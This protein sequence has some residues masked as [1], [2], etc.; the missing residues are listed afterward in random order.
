MNELIKSLHKGLIVSYQ[1][2]EGNPLRAP[3]HMAAMA[4]AAELGGAVAIRA[5]GPVD[6]AAIK[7]CV[8]IPVIGIY[9]TERSLEIPYITPDFSYAE[10]IARL[11][12]E[13][14]ALD[15]TNRPRPNGVDLK[16]LI[17]RIKNELGVLVMA[18]I[19]T[20][21]EGLMASEY[22]A[23]LVATT[24]SGY[25]SYSPLI[26]GP[27]LELIR[28][29]K[30]EIDTPI[31]AEGRFTSPQDVANGIEAGAH[32]VVVGKAITNVQFSTNHFIKEAGL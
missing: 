13:I 32:A 11:G 18:D 27:D 5:N 8:H 23:D 28:R 20:F 9:K 19:S 14:V 12:V 29:L 30:N 15:A 22:G 17:S 25:T 21:E 6:I 31:I 7:E 10:K 3:E 24:L 26:D 4:L 1:A 16:T 2:L